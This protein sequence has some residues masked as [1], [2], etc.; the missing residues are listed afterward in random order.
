ML[1]T[2]FTYFTGTKFIHPIWN[3]FRM[4]QG[5]FRFR[6]LAV[7]LAPPFFPHFLVSPVLISTLTS[8]DLRLA[9]DLKFYSLTMMEERV[10]LVSNVS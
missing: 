4:G 1:S 9:G 8:L 6:C 5:G 10:E 2:M 3:M 7:S